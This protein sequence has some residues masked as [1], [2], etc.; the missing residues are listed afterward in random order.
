MILEC[1]DP[2]E[3]KYFRTYPGCY[4]TTVVTKFDLV[5]GEV[6]DAVG[7]PSGARN[8]RVAVEGNFFVFSFHLQSKM[9]I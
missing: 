5:A 7:I 6:F 3:Y 2:T 4:I 9:N 1:D 8:V